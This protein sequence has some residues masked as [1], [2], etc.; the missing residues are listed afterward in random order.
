MVMTTSA[1][2]K[3]L[4]NGKLLDK[5]VFITG[6]LSGIGKACAVAAAKE[7]ANVVVVDI[8]SVTYDSAMREIQS[9]N[10]KSI[11]IECDVTVTGQVKNAI[12]KTIEAFGSLDVALN[13]AGINGGGERVGNTTE[14]DWNSV[15]H[16]NLSSVFICMKY[17]LTQMA[18]QKNG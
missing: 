3:K 12:E 17:E 8:K 2:E 1:P 16:V 13:N 10:K 6:G 5:T 11:F 18:R 9:E 14:E 4:T 7:G 15:I